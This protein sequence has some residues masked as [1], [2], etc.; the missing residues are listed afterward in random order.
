MYEDD[1]P[2]PLV[3]V[4]RWR[5]DGEGRGVEWYS[6]PDV[7]KLL[8]ID[9]SNGDYGIVLVAVAYF[10]H[11]DELLQACFL[12]AET[13]GLEETVVA[14]K[15]Q[16]VVNEDFFESFGKDVRHLEVLVEFNLEEVGFLFV[17]D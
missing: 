6:E 3:I 9:I 4:E 14:H 5:V 1:A 7:C 16:F 8:A 17:D 13:V 10:L 2:I 12:T 15:A 11:L